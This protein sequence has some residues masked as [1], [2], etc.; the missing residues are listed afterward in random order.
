MSRLRLL[1][2]CES[3]EDLD[4]RI[5]PVGNLPRGP[6][7]LLIDV[8]FAGVNPS[9]VRA[10]MGVMPQAVFP[11]TPGREWSGVV[12]DGPAELVGREVFGAGGDLG[13]TRDGSHG[14]RLVLPRAAAVMKPASISLAAAGSMGVPF[15]TAALSY[16]EAGLPRPGDVVLI[17]AVN[18]NVGQAAAQI[19]AMHGARVFG[20][21]RRA[22]PFAGPESVP[23]R[24][25]DSS[26]ADVAEVVR[27]ETGGH[28]ADI[29]VNTI[30]S[31]YFASANASM[32]HGGRQVLMSTQARPVPFDIFTFYRGR[33]SFFGIDTL[34]MD[35]TASAALLRELLPGFESGRLRPFPV[36]EHECVP[37]GHAK[38]A[39]RATVEGTRRR[40]VLR[41]G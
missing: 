21:V 32:A 38:E 31:A 26:S 14:S 4:L 40:V 7:D 19:A 35:A 6:D 9:D 11:R 25:I 33:H 23:V 17:M 27:A 29:V 12:L 5:E 8:R 37:L 24:M 30:G 2:K 3:L 39:Y 22:E 36:E 16:R 13:I 15:V 28:G 1:R 18:G 20:V 41:T 10:T 34:A